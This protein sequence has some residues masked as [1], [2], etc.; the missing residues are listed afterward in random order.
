MARRK[1]RIICKS[2]ES[3]AVKHIPAASALPTYSPPPK[4]EADKLYDLIYEKSVEGYCFADDEFGMPWIDRGDIEE[5]GGK[6]YVIRFRCPANRAH[7]AFFGRMAEKVCE[8]MNCRLHFIHSTKW[9]N[10]LPFEDCIWIIQKDELDQG[11][12]ED[13]DNPD[14]G[15]TDLAEFEEIEGE[16]EDESTAEEI[17]ARIEKT[18]EEF[19]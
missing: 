6:V 1:P 14:D 7:H 9:E 13:E 17:D 11:E 4:T 5:H 2:V 8:E 18:L 10:K 16:I 15:S 3:R 19:V 12:E